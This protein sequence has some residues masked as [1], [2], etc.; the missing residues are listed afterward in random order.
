MT[1]KY[2]SLLS[3]FRAHGE[4][5]GKPPIPE[6]ADTKR[7]ERRPTVASLLVFIA[8]FGVAA[9]QPLYLVWA[10]GPVS[11]S[12]TSVLVALV[13]S[14]TGLAFMVEMTVGQPFLDWYHDVPR[15]GLP[16]VDR[17]AIAQE[18]TEG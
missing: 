6:W 16:Q 10:L 3:Y 13:L 8:T 1:G 7:G 9:T 4:Y 11:A 5:G 17:R 15:R 18:V 14:C 2:G 12:Q